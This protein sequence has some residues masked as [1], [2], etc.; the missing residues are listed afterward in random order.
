MTEHS[1]IISAP[2]VYNGEIISHRD[3]MLSLTDM[4]IAGGRDDAKR[5]ANWARKEGA[6]FI[7]AVS[8]MIDV[9]MGHIQT[10][11]GGRG[12]GGTTF[13]H[14]QIA[15]AYAKYLSPEFHMWCNQ[16]VRERMENKAVAHNG[17]VKGVVS[18][19]LTELVPALVAQHIAEGEFGIVHGVT[20]FDVTQMAGVTDRRRL[21]GLGQFISNR[22]RMYHAQEGVAVK[23]RD[24][25]SMGPVLV[26]DKALSK[27]WLASGGKG[28]YVLRKPMNLAYAGAP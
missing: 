24:Q 10:T 4:W 27:Q 5:P 20:S 6:A 21:R 14:W 13:A 22:L 19:A 1:N 15:L 9:P 17:I 25:G 23:L 18:K 3:D 12:I 7:S 11:R 16:V 28:D 8:V 26:Y 2:L